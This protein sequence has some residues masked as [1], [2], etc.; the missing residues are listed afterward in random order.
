MSFLTVRTPLVL[1]ARYSAWAFS[2]FDLAKPDSCTVPLSVS[3]LMEAAST[4]LSST[5][6]AFTAVVVAVSSM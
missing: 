1:R 6:L 5:N 4:V 2:A 3:T